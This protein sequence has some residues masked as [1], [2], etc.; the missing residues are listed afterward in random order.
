MCT[1]G[2]NIEGG[3]RGGCTGNP[4]LQE[5]VCTGGSI[6]QGKVCTGDPIWRGKVYTGDPI[7]Q[8]KVCT[9]N[10]IWRGKCAQ[11]CGV[12]TGDTTVYYTSKTHCKHVHVQHMY[13]TWKIS[14]NLS[15]FFSYHDCIFFNC[16]LNNKTRTIV[17][18]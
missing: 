6:L 2:P 8:G 18:P 16:F 13:C 14:V 4:I 7:L 3:R 11:C 10:P 12:V 5:R 9:G 17:S 1:K 15:I